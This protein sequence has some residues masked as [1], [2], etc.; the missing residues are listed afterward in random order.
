MGTHIG[1]VWGTC[2]L[3]SIWDQFGIEFLRTGM[4]V[5]TTTFFNLIYFF[6]IAKQ[7]DISY[8]KVR[9]LTDRR[10]ISY[11]LLKTA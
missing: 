7:L 6:F 3:F 5:A 9:R 10:G 1:P 2:P 8:L 4:V 11:I